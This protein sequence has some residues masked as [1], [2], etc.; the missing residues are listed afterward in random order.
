MLADRDFFPEEL[1]PGYSWLEDE[2]TFDPAVDLAL[3]DPTETRSL[4]DLGYPQ[5][6]RE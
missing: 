3:G 1:P 2:P 4:E 5:S 6:F